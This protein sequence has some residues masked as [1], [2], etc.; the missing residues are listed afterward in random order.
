MLNGINNEKIKI[1]FFC[2]KVQ[3]SLSYVESICLLSAK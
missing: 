3:N 2:N 1:C